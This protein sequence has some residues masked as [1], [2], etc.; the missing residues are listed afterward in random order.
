MEV[1][2]HARVLPYSR[3]GTH[4]S[5]QRISYRVHELPT[6][7]ALANPELPRVPLDISRDKA[8]ASSIG[9]TYHSRSWRAKLSKSSFGAHS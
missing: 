1:F 4:L 3:H 2:L 7:A 5:L 8:M 6:K 9:H